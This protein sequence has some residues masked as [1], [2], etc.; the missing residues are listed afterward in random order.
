MKSSS[1]AIFRISLFLSLISGCAFADA[2]NESGGPASSSL[3]AASSTPPRRCDLEKYLRT[4]NSLYSDCDEADLRDVN[5]EGADL[6]GVSLRG[7]NL[8]GANLEGASLIGADLTPMVGWKNGSIYETSTSVT[9]ANLRRANLRTVL[10]GVNFSRSDLTGADLRNSES[11][12]AS[13]RFA[14]LTN[15]DLT[16]AELSRVDWDYAVLTNAN[17]SGANLSYSSFWSAKT[18]AGV[19]LSGATMPDKEIHD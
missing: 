10:N 3:S 17:L 8:Q 16:D 1:L 11:I 6:S 5:L 15:A 7:A 9:D 2:N 14:N 13:F 19:V 18:M 4:R 12:Q